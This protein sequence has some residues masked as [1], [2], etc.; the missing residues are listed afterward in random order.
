MALLE[1]LIVVHVIFSTDLIVSPSP[2]PFYDSMIEILYSR[3]Y[4]TIM[5]LIVLS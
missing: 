5:L 1:N 3:L 2:L 4:K